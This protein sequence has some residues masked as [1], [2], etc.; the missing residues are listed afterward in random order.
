[1]LYVIYVSIKLKE[2]KKDFLEDIMFNF[3][4][5]VLVGQ[6]LLVITNI[7]KRRWKRVTGIAYTVGTRK[8]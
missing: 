4:T 8:K 7:I 3:I 1:M 2:K 5:E 6:E